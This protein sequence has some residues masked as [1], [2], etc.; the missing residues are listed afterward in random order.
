M[1]DVYKIFYAKQPLSIESIL[2]GSNG[3]MVTFFSFYK[4]YVAEKSSVDYTKFDYICSDGFF[5]ILLNKIW[6]GKKSLRISFDMTSLA[7]VILNYLSEHGK[8]VYF[9]GST[10]NNMVKFIHRIKDNFPNLE[11]V[12]YRNGYFTE[13]EESDIYK[14]IVAL[15]PFVVVIGM[16]APLQEKFAVGLRAA[17]YK[18]NIY[19]CG[20]FIHQS[21]SA[22]NYY[23]SYIDKYNLRWLYR[24]YKEPKV[25]KRVFYLPIFSLKYTLI[26]IAN[27]IRNKL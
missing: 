13:D 6:G 10:D 24:Y 3:V 22:L 9:I 27:K 17:G 25:L 18:G 19:T 1:F 7:P 20:G 16:G 2:P 15:S 8:S 5:P 11:I 12:G 4:L 21:V 23:P 26:L 14:K